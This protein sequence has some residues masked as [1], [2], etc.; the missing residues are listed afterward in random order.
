MIGS[1]RPPMG[2]VCEHRDRK[3]TKA[4]I[5]NWLLLSIWAAIL[6]N[7]TSSSRTWDDRSLV[8]LPISRFQVVG[9]WFTMYLTW[10]FVGWCIA[11]ALFRIPF[12][13]I[14]PLLILVAFQTLLIMYVKERLS[15]TRANSG[16]WMACLVFPVWLLAPMRFGMYSWPEISPITASPWILWVLIPLTLFAWHRYGSQPWPATWKRPT[17]RESIAGEF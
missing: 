4:N 10:F 17:E 13:E 2:Q 16:W 11:I 5:A 6:C 12:M 7:M 15:G 3:S 9:T 1:K 8:H 14:T